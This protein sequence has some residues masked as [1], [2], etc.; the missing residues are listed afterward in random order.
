MRALDLQ[1]LSIT[2]TC[3]QYHVY[4]RRAGLKIRSP[5]TGFKSDLRYARCSV[6]GLESTDC[7]ISTDAR[8][9]G[10][11]GLEGRKMCRTKL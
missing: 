10:R 1:T 9:F 2:A 3:F 6:T 5:E 8:H 7:P 11:P 4:G